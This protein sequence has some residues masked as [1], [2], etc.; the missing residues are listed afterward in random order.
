MYPE[1][2]FIDGSCEESQWRASKLLYRTTMSHLILAVSNLKRKS[3]IKKPPR[4]IKFSL[5][6]SLHRTLHR[7]R[8]PLPP[9]ELES[10]H[11]ERQD[12]MSDQL[13]Q[14]TNQPGRFNKKAIF[15]GGKFKPPARPFLRP[16]RSDIIKDGHAAFFASIFVPPHDVNWWSVREGRSEAAG[17]VARERSDRTMGDARTWAAHLWERRGRE[18]HWKCENVKVLLVSGIKIFLRQFINLLTI[19]YIFH[20]YLVVIQ[21]LF[22]FRFHMRTQEFRM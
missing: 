2:V 7:T 16:A 13:Q 14:P 5:N 19:E 22:W 18:S 15:F 10:L 4:F 6:S 3:Y 1:Y 9:R 12:G 20:R 8:S 11:Q 17:R 21:V